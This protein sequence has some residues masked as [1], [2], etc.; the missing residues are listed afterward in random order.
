MKKPTMLYASPFWPM[1]SGIS[2]YS[3]HLLQA[4]KKYFTITLL[5]DGYEL[6][7]ER[8]K[9][10]P[11]IRYKKGEVYKGQDVVLYNIGNQPDFHSYM[12]DA[13]EYNPGYVILHDFSLYYLTI[14]VA[15]RND[16]VFS[17]IYQHTGIDGI[18]M[19]KDSL[20]KKP[21]WNL[22][23]H[24]DLADKLPMNRGVLER[25]KGILVHSHYA[26]QSIRKMGV[27]TDICCVNHL[28]TD[29]PVGNISPANIKKMAKDEWD[30]PE[31]AFVLVA[32][33]FIGT[34][35]QNVLTCKAVEIYNASHKDKIYY[36]MAGEG[37]D[38][39]PYLGTYC[40]K[41]GFLPDDLYTV[42]IRRADVIMNLRYPTNGETSGTMIQGMQLGKPCVTTAIGWFD[43]LPDDAVI[44]LPP[45]I[46]AEELAAR[47]DR[48][49]IKSLEKLGARAK[50]YIRREY[51]PDKIARQMKVFLTGA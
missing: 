2:N 30:V 51:D 9:E 8:C 15:Q 38:A 18:Q 35:K 31:D 34:T 22:L 17:E 26:E 25:T 14:G 41:T 46:T 21:E 49:D 40:K 33:G 36:L 32:A 1:K 16:R 42:A 4:L 27:Q 39:D 6:E 20:R 10:F 47:F 29:M 44:K 5:T 7:D 13:M 19:V 45:T 23:L 3:S 37:P 11:V 12:L 50:E 43:E 48:W 28:M 24:K